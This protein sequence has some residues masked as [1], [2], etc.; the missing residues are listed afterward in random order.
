MSTD[1]ITIHVNS[2]V[3]QAYLSASEED[4]RKMDFLA[5]FQL[6]EYLRSPEPLEKVIEDMSRETQSRGLTPEILE[7]LLH[8]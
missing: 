8:D 4:R 1:A 5:G 2:E 3:A 7:S 6:A